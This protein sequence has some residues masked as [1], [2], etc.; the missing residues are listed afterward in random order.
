[1]L[2]F[3]GVLLSSLTLFFGAPFLRV[4]WSRFG[5]LPY[6]LAGFAFLPVFIFMGGSWAGAV[7][8]LVGVFSELESRG[9]RW[10]WSGLTSL[11]VSSGVLAGGAF[12]WLSTQKLTTL[13]S[14][15]EEIHKLLKNSQFWQLP[16]IDQMVNLLQV[17]PGLVVAGLILTLAHALIFEK[18]V[19]QFLAA[20]RERFAGQVRLL[21]FKLPDI[22]V[23]IA[24]VSFLGSFLTW[25]GKPVAENLFIICVALFLLQGVAILE[26]F[27]NAIRAHWFVRALG[28]FLFVFQL[29]VALAFIGFIDFWMDFRDRFR[30][31]KSNTQTTGM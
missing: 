20:P 19:Y 29:F 13:T 10:I 22:F 16:T 5:S 25:P 26:C 1:M 9:I 17:L 15:A 12:Y 23:W 11:S 4:L 8:I 27:F 18:V 6:W 24:M 7:W 30:K 3:L 21:E 31:M 2:S 14:I 28:Y